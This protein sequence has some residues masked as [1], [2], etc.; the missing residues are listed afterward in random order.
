MMGDE[1]KSRLRRWPTRSRR[2]R[3]FTD[4]AETPS[5]APPASSSHGTSANGSSHTVKG[6]GCQ[7]ATRRHHQRREQH[8]QGQE[9]V[10]E[11]GHDGDR[12]K[13]LRRAHHLGQQRPVV[14]EGHRG[15]EHRAGKE[16]PRQQTAEEKQGIRITTRE[17]AG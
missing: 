14:D 16:Q 1:K 2:S 17:T 15:I 10:N 4:S 6:N 5:A 8:R 9:V 7:P 13:D 12:G 3:N 11:V